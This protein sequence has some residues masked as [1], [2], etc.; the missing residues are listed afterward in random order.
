MT[1]SRLLLLKEIFKAILGGAVLSFARFRITDPLP[2]ATWCQETVFKLF[3]KYR[4]KVGLRAL[5]V[6]DIEPNVPPGTPFIL[7]ANGLSLKIDGDRRSIPF[8]ERGGK[9]AG[10]PADDAAAIA[11]LERLRLGG[12]Q[13]IIFPA[14]M[15]YWLDVYPELK[16]RLLTQGRCVV[17]NHR[18][19][20]YDLRS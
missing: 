10:H 6:K 17:N 8:P 9:W 18:A 15:F 7:V 14:P 3:R 12:A 20:I 16:K 1:E 13:F 5:G 11:E 2:F 19:L 4:Y